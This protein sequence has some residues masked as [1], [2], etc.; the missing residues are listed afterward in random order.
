M[1]TKCAL[2]IYNTAI[3]YGDFKFYTYLHTCSEYNLIY[4]ACNVIEH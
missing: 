4:I 2:L 3:G 1:I